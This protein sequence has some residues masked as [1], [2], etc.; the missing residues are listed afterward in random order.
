MTSGINIYLESITAL[1]GV[2]ATTVKRTKR[3]GNVAGTRWKKKVA[4]EVGRDGWKGE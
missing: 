1:V 2:E 4:G 3:W